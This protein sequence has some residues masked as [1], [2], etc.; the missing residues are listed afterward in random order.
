MLSMQ[1]DITMYSFM[2]LYGANEPAMYI[3]I[4]AVLLKTQVVITYDIHIAKA[5]MFVHNLQ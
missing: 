5:T 2:T 3:A 4:H 1:S